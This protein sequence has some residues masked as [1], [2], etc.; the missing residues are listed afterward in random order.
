MTGDEPILFPHPGPMPVVD[1]ARVERIRTRSRELYGAPLRLVE[2]LVLAEEDEFSPPIT[3]TG[4]SAPRPRRQ[5]KRKHPQPTLTIVE[6]EPDVV[7]EE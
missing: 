1:E 3:A 7:D 4:E 2:P 6:G 5:A